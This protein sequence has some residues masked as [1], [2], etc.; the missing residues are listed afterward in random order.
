MCIIWNKDIVELSRF[1]DRYEELKNSIDEYNSTFYD[2]MH[3]DV[4]GY[5]EE[6]PNISDKEFELAS[7]DLTADIAENDGRINEIKK[8]ENKLV[9]KIS[10]EL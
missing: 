7:K 3:F 9:T 2:E 8:E 10:I 5:K 1:I 6:F 4:L